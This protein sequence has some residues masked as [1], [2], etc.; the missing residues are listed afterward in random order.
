MFNRCHQLIRT[1]SFLQ[2]LRFNQRLRDL[3]SEER[4]TGGA[5]EYQ[6]AQRID[7]RVFAEQADEQFG[8]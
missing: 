4:V 8:R 2:V 6:I 1:G 3:L 7:T 5:F